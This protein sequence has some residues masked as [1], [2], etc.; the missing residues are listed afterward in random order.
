MLLHSPDALAAVSLSS[1]TARLLQRNVV[2]TQGRLPV[3]SLWVSHDAFPPLVSRV[4]PSFTRAGWGWHLRGFSP[5]L[6]A[7]A[8]VV[9]ARRAGSSIGTGA[10]CLDDVLG[11]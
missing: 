8:V 9:G 6:L 4:L 7:S 1:G 10:A 2:S 3:A 11:V 5:F